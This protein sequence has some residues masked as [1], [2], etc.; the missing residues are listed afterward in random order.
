MGARDAIQT[1]EAHLNLFYGGVNFEGASRDPDTPVVMT[2]R[3]VVQDCSFHD[4]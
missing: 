1:Q 4:L 3:E 2:S